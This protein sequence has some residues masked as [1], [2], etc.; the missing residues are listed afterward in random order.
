MLSAQLT[1]VGL[2]VAKD[3]DSDCGAILAESGSS[4]KA[5]RN[6]CTAAWMRI[7]LLYFWNRD[8]NDDR[9][10]IGLNVLCACV[11]LF[12]P[13][14]NCG[15]ESNAISVRK[16]REIFRTP[17]SSPFQITVKCIVKQKKEQKQKAE[18]EAVSKAKR[19]S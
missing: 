11:S 14:F 13:F 6:R 15:E 4:G 19:K 12:T 18:E 17:R 10:P 2:P 16:S 8:N 9:E 1:V 3:S 5:K 7:I